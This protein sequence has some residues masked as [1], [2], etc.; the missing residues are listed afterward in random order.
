MDPIG[1]RYHERGTARSDQFSV[2]NFHSY[3]NKADESNNSV[4]GTLQNPSKD[5]VRSSGRIVQPL[6]A[7]HVNE[8]GQRTRLI[9]RQ[10]LSLE[11]P[12][13]LKIF[14]LESCFA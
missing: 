1:R 10:Q 4:F 5:V 11:F 7:A 14:F 9:S 3:R 12:D 2:P 13:P 8:F 6:V